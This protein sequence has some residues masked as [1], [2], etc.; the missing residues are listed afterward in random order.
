MVGRNRWVVLLD[1]MMPAMNGYQLLGELRRRGMAPAIIVMSAAPDLTALGGLTVLQKPIRSGAA[2]HG[3]C[4]AF[5]LSGLR[6]RTAAGAL[7]P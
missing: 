4:G 1:L 3:H 2:S 5:Q 7:A 6:V